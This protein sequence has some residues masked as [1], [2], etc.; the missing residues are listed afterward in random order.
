MS[1]RR[2]RPP[3]LSENRSADAVR[4]DI[5]DFY[6]SEAEERASEE[7]L[8]A[9]GT[10]RVPESR[11]AHY[12]VDRKVDAALEA[13]GLPATADVLEVGSS[14]GQMTFL[15]ADRFRA[16]TAVDLSAD[17]VDL[18]RR[19]AERYG[20]DNVTVEVSDAE[21]LPFADGAFDAAFSWSVLRY[22]PHP[23]RALSEMHRVLRP[24]GRL[25]VDFPNKYCPWFGP[26][27]AILRIKPHV[28]DRLFSATEV[29]R[30]AIDAGFADVRTRPMLFTTRRLPDGLLP[31]ARVTDALLERTPGLRQLAAVILVTGRKP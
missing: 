6:R 23:E 2:Q 4:D 28:H 22:V 31:A 21:H 15:L 26:V 16:V 30:M 25:A 29:R 11:A 7:W 3:A 13:S 5:R 18:T 10:A 1:G 9:G 12:F 20:V 8:A 17:A 14:F 27:K 19:R 24:G